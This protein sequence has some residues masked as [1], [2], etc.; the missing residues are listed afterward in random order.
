[1]KKAI[2]R[3]MLSMFTILE[4]YF[5]FYHSYLEYYDVWENKA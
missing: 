5:A 2:K 3:Q 1:M 4:R